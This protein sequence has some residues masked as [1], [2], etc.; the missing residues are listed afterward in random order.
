MI[1]AIYTVL[2]FAIGSVPFAFWLARHRL[3]VDVRKYGADKNPGALNAFRAGGWEV[4]LPGG[5]LDFF[6]GFVPVFLAQYGS[7]LSGWPSF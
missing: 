5:L 4:G 3:G 2:G 1:V 7:H 6:K